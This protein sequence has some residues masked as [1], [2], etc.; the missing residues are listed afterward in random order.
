MGPKQEKG[1]HG[2]A[3]RIQVDVERWDVVIL[4]NV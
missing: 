4:A 2:D 1:S 3:G